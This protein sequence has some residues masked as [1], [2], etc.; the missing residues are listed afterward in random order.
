MSGWL[1]FVDLFV[2]QSSPFSQIPFPFLSVSVSSASRKDELI[3]CVNRSTDG[4][5]EP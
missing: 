3:H 4:W 5:E 2:G 1:V